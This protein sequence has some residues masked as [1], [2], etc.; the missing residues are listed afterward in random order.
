[1]STQSLTILP[2]LFLGV[3]LGFVLTAAG[4]AAAL[5][6][7]VVATAFALRHLRGIRAVQKD[8]ELAQEKTQENVEATEALQRQIEK[9]VE[10]TEEIRRQT[11]AALDLYETIVD[12]EPLARWVRQIA[13][14][15]VQIQSYADPLLSQLAQRDLLK[16]REFMAM[17]ASGRI[18]ISADDF[19]HTE[20]LL[21][22]LLETAEE[23]DEFWASTL[24][25]AAFWDHANPY[26]Q[27]QADKVQ[28]G[29]KVKRVFVFETDSDFHDERAQ[30]HMQ[31]QKDR[32]I[33]VKYDVRSLLAVRDLTVVLKQGATSDD[34]IPT[35][36]MECKVGSSKRIN[37]IELWY[38]NELHSEAVKTAWRALRDI[39]ENAN[40]L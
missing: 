3:D 32:A 8:I 30:H 18:T 24:V 28:Q 11:L 27:D 39:F 15:F 10:K 12:E 34:L 7:S 31:C 33:A 1:M 9:N 17:S 36:A 19:E 35:Y 26:L 23:G 14:E 29:V 22:V 21:R 2:T 16:S 4:F 25:H 6:G 5:V 37:H 13:D 38:A 20:A 40:D